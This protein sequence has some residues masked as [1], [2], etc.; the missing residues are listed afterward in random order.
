MSDMEFMK[1]EEGDLIS[2]LERVDTSEVPKK[3]MKID[4]TLTPRLL[5]N[6]QLG[7]GGAHQINQAHSSN[8]LAKHTLRI[9]QIKSKRICCRDT[10]CVGVPKPD[11]VTVC[12]IG[13]KQV[14]QV[15]IS[16]CKRYLYYGTANNKFFQV[17][18]VKLKRQMCDIEVVSETDGNVM[19]E[20]K[21]VTARDR[22]PV[23]LELTKTFGQKG[24][25][26][27]E[28]RKGQ[29]GI[30]VIELSP[31]GLKILTSGH[32]SATVEVLETDITRHKGD[33]E[34][35]QVKNLEH[36]SREIWTR[37]GVIKE[38]GKNYRQGKIT[39]G[40]W[41]DEETIGVVGIKG[42]LTVCK[43]RG[44]CGRILIPTVTEV[45]FPEHGLPL[46]SGHRFPQSQEL[47]RLNGISHMSLRD[48]SIITSDCGEVYI[49]KN[50]NTDGVTTRGARRIG[51]PREELC[52][53]DQY[54][55]IILLSQAI[56]EN[57]NTVV[58]GTL[59]GL[60]ILDTRM[61]HILSHIKMFDVNNSLE[62]RLE[63]E[64]MGL[65]VRLAVNDQIVT[66]ALWGGYITYCDLRAK[67]WILE[68][69]SAHLEE[70]YRKVSWPLGL[71]GHPVHRTIDEFLPN[72]Y[73]L[74]SMKKRDG[75][76]A[77][78]G[79]PIIGNLS[80]SNTESNHLEGIVTIWD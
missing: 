9:N 58:V 32:H 21:I 37:D 25:N 31:N 47:S 60:S 23:V 42:K 6:R 19:E 55:N 48:E 20:F 10:E 51:I 1:A 22:D 14:T 79:G 33:P 38:G 75:V 35:Y 50:D 28:N 72:L 63:E 3:I 34:E 44:E 70:C 54:K 62:A 40:V 69:N 17:D 26:E 11:K 18:L 7:G 78:G 39:G 41:F 24:W 73:P 30:H 2:L 12:P 71:S 16:K 52:W 68:E 13:T 53:E 5:A 77:A 29:M 64:M 61:P 74:T 27:I 57:S 15:E 46:A 43:L 45:T 66:A 36:D 67:K 59:F 80:E 76:L 4:P 49:L 8:V 56:E 65:P